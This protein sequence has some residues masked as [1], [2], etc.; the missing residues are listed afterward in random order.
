MSVTHPGS[1]ILSANATAATADATAATRDAA[2]ARLARRRIGILG[3][4]GA[5]YVYLLILFGAM[6]R[7]TGSGLGCG[8]DWPRCHGQ[9]LPAWD[10][11]T[12]IE[13]GHRLLGAG[14]L[15]P[16]GLLVGAVALAYRRSGADLVGDVLGPTAWIVALLLVQALLGAI[17][18]KLDLPAAVIALHF[19]TASTI[20]ALLL[21]VAVRTFVPG[22]ALWSRNSRLLA[23]MAVLALVAIGWGALTANSGASLACQGFPLCNGSVAPAAPGG[24]ASWIV[25]VHWTHRLLAYMLA[26]AVLCLA[27]G[28]LRRAQP[29]RLRGLAAAALSLVGLQVAIGA[30]LVTLGLPPA[31]RRLHVIVGV[32]LFAT[33]VLWALLARR[34]AGREPGLTGA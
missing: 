33:L 26:L 10:L 14:A 24:R 32:L 20:L 16:F 15:L 28:A 3:A 21:L 17:T 8:N 4:W 19:V 18:V 12:W 2:A 6:V 31:L 34:E 13:W 1:V 11:T 23:A 7:L 30:G 27:A 22:P 5:A 25:G 29:A 9:W